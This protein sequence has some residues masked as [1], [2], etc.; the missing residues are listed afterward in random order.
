MNP[1]QKPQEDVVV[2]HEDR[3]AAWAFRPREIRYGLMDKWLNGEFDECSTIQAFARHRLLGH[4]AGRRDMREAARKRCLKVEAVPVVQK[5]RDDAVTYYRTIGEY[6]TDMVAE[7]VEDDCP[8]IQALARAR[9]SAFA[10]GAMYMRTK[11][12]EAARGSDHCNSPTEFAVRTTR[13][14]I[15]NHIAALPTEPLGGEG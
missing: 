4:E 6:F 2:T 9:L 1:H 8:L 14:T 10:D 3:E 7:G 15:A 12:E 13:R 5:D 11:A